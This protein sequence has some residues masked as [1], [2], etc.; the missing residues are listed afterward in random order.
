MTASEMTSTL[1]SI[2][3]R[4]ADAIE[5]QARWE[6]YEIRGDR[7][8]RLAENVRSELGTFYDRIRDAAAVMDTVNER[9]RNEHPMAGN[10]ANEPIS[11]SSMRFLADEWEKND[12][13]W[14]GHCQACGAVLTPP[15]AT[16]CR[17]CHASDEDET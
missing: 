6:G 8:A 13:P 7:L 16:T 4:I 9:F 2:E 10:S 12:K 5:K 1:T 3:Q 14:P 17:T 15:A 11:A